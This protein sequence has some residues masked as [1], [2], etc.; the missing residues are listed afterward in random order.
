MRQIVVLLSV[1]VLFAACGKDAG[2]AGATLAVR[3]GTLIDG[4]A[5]AALGGRLVV[6]HDQRITEVLPKDA[7]VPE[8][9]TLLDLEGYTCLP[10]LIDTHT[11]LAGNHDESSDLSLLYTRPLAETVASTERNAK[12]RK[13]VV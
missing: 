12:D 4:I 7:A 5:D 10:G 8:G 11:H 13:S 6:I 9:A 1:I 2:D 3:C